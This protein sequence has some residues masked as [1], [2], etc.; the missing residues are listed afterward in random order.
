MMNKKLTAE[1]VREAIEK[2]FEFDVWVPAERWQAIADELNMKLGSEVCEL[3]WILQFKTNTQEF[4]RCECSNCGESFGVED[5]SSFPF[6]MTIDKVDIPNFCSNC[7][8][9]VTITDE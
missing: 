9:K 4:W 3:N 5:R 2:R 7:G 1:Q 8:A 6:K